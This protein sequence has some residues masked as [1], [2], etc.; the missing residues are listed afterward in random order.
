VADRPATS[1]AAAAEASGR[2]VVRR[3]FQLLALALVAALLALLTWTLITQETGKAF[4]STIKSGERPPAPA[5]TLPVI[6]DSTETWPVEL[7]SALDDDRVSLEELRGYPVVINF[8]ASWCEPCK[9]EAPLLSA[10]AAERAGQVV[11][12]GLDVQD[13]VGDARHFLERYGASNYVSVRDPSNRVYEAYGLTGVPET[14][15][16]DSE[17]RAVAHTLGELSEQDLAEGIAAISVES[18]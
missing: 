5:F 6:W 17:G 7:L 8:W 11:F 1:E 3:V 4:V 14:F 10:A 18:R 2:G 15:Y 12:L 16:L 13:F 9:D